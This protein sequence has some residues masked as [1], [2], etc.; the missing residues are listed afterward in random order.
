MTAH[1]KNNI[2]TVTS[3]TL[4]SQS[5]MKDG[6]KWRHL[7]SG[8]LVSFEDHNLLNKIY[9]MGREKKNGRGGFKV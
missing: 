1:Y 5:Y 4:H 2:L 3:D 9:Q 8:K 6:D 7:N